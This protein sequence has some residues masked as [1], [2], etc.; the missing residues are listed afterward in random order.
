M[1]GDAD[2]TDVS[3]AVTVKTV[4]G[5]VQASGIDSPAVSLVT[6]SGDAHWAF[7]A[8]FSSSFAGTTV[9]GDVTLTLPKESDTRLEMNTT[10]GGLT[11]SV[12]VTEAVTADR[13]A[14]GTLGGG[15]G[16]VRLQSVSGDLKVE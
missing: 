7:L 3:G 5:D 8:P 12:P 9:S 6:V 11:I 13:H 10:S 14:A 4:S 2:V 15:V 1:S 16:S